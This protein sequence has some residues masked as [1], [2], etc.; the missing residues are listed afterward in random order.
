MAV[1]AKRPLPFANPPVERQDIVFSHPSEAELARVLDYYGIAWKYEPITFPLEWDENGALL[2]AFAPDFYLVDQDLFVELTTLR[3][4]LMRIKRRKIRRIQELYPEV[5]IKLWNRQD[6]C[7]FLERF[8][9][10][11]RE[12]SL[13]GQQALDNANGQ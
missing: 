5:N 4:K 11:D 6:F 9:L 3:S 2:E 1:D 7:H 12:S 13:V 10:Q 8:G